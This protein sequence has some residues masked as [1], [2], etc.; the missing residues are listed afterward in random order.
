[1]GLDSRPRCRVGVGSRSSIFWPSAFKGASLRSPCRSDGAGGCS[2]SPPPGSPLLLPA[3]LP[4]LLPGAGRS[5]LVFQSATRAA[6]GEADLKLAKPT[7]SLRAG[8]RRVGAAVAAA[9]L[10]SVLLPFSGA[11]SEL[12][13]ADA[14]SPAVDASTFASLRTLPAP[15]AAA[16]AGCLGGLKLPGGGAGGMAALSRVLV[17]LA[18]RRKAAEP[19]E[20]LRCTA[21][22]GGALALELVAASAFDFHRARRSA[23]GLEARKDDLRAG[24]A[25]RPPLRNIP[26]PLLPPPPLLA[27][28]LSPPVLLSTLP[29]AGAAEAV[30]ACASAAALPGAAT[31]ASTAAAAAAGA[32]SPAAAVA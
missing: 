9:V 24:M 32:G 13:P 19:V 5:A 10:P 6:T 20:A 1:M 12:L 29:P 2:R 8:T 28:L 7:E 30:L 26:A 3:L 11:A 15:P 31:E 16:T 14:P 4:L 23:M 25:G 27:P 17:R 22:N 18:A 21:R